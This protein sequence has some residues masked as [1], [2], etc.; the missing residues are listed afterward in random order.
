MSN[1]QSTSLALIGLGIIVILA[2]IAAS[3]SPL[4]IGAAILGLLGVAG[5]TRLR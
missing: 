1:N 2:G 3:L 5:V 4:G